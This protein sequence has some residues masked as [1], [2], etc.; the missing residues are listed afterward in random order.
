MRLK[1]PRHEH[2]DEVSHRFPTAS[3]IWPYVFAGYVP[4]AILLNDAA[5][6][7]QSQ[8]WI[9]HLLDAQ[10]ASGTGWLGPPPSVRDGG[11]L[12]WPQVS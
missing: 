3:E 1:V 5:Q 2:S 12:Y 10:S 9:D 4:Q 8:Q 11:M 7:A 6:L